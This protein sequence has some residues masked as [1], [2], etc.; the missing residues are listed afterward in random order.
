MVGATGTDLNDSKSGS[1]FVFKKDVGG[2]NNW[3]QIKTLI[4]SDGQKNDAFGNDVAIFDGTIVVGARLSDTLE[5]DA[6]AAYIYD[7]NFGG[8]NNWGEVK[9][10]QSS[11]P[12][13]RDNFAS[14]VAIDGDTVV[15]SAPFSQR[16]AF[17]YLRNFGGVNEWGEVKKIEVDDSSNRFG[18]S[19]IVIADDLLVIG[20]YF[21]QGAVTNPGSNGS[22][23]VYGFSR[24]VGGQENWGEVAKIIDN[25]GLPGAGFGRSVAIDGNFMVIGRHLSIGILTPPGAAYLFQRDSTNGSWNQA[26]KIDDFIDFSGSRFGYSVSVDGEFAAVG[27]FRDPLVAPDAGS[28]SILRKRLPTDSWRL[29][30]KVTALDAQA[31]DFFGRSVSLYRNTLAVGAYTEDENGSNSGAIYI[32]ERGLEQWPQAAKLL[33]SDGA[34]ADRLGQSISLE[35]NTLVAGA[36]FDN[37]NGSKSGSAYVFERNEGGPNKWGEVRKLIASDGLSNELFGISV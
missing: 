21:S 4:A 3:G 1:A 17:V 16:A 31:G 25:D 19:S 7:E 33:A 36:F 5:L 22:G 20:D 11:N 9:K 28:V 30:D 15:V 6:G 32:F 12:K 26:Q 10:L 2:V 35:R 27:A 18:F 14:S 8:S 23:A 13:L 34:A 37:D 24:D 29:V